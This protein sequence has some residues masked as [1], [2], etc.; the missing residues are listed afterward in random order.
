MSENHLTLTEGGTK[1]IQDVSYP[2]TVNMGNIPADLYVYQLYWKISQGRYSLIT[3]HT[4]LS[5]P[6]LPLP[7]FVTWYQGMVC[8]L[9]PLANQVISLY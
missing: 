2:L 9:F 4:E 1:L 6:H 8:Y 7:I 3:H 5:L